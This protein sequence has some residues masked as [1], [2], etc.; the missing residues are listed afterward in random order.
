MCIIATDGLWR[1]NKHASFGFEGCSFFIT[2]PSECNGA[3]NPSMVPRSK[4]CPTSQRHPKKLPVHDS[5]PR[6]PTRRAQQR[7]VQ[8]TWG[9]SQPTASHQFKPQLAPDNASGAHQGFKGDAAVKSGML[10]MRL[11]RVA[12]GLRALDRAG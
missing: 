5:P 4:P 8:K 1:P 9:R 3:E 7:L 6:Y 11:A 12:K 10:A 2:A